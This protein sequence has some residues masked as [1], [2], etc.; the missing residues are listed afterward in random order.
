VQTGVDEER[1]V[2]GVQTRWPSHGVDAE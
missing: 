2:A 1:R